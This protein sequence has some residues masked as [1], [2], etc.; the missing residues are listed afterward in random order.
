M[1]MMSDLG[2]LL[3]YLKIVQW[4]PLITDIA[5]QT[6]MALYLDQKAQK[7]WPAHYLPTFGSKGCLTW[8]HGNLD[9]AIPTPQL[10]ILQLGNKGTCMLFW[11]MEWRQVDY[12]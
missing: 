6:V 8:I 7:T 11:E 10:I 9:I 5:L 12:P 2:V 1:L 3:E 4:F